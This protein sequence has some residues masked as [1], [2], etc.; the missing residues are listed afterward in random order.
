MQN[1][2]FSFFLK[3]NIA[4]SVK[5]PESK[6]THTGQIME[7]S[8]DSEFRAAVLNAAERLQAKLVRFSSRFFGGDIGRGHDV[9]QH[10]FLQLC[11]M[12]VEACP[13]NMDA[14]LFRVC[15]NRAIDLRRREDRQVTGQSGDWMDHM[16]DQ[17]TPVGDKL[18]E[19]ELFQ[20]V[21]Q[22]IANLPESQREA[23]ELWSNGFCY[24]EI[25]KILERPESTV[26]VLVH[27]AL[28]KLRT[29][30][31]IIAATGESVSTAG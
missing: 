31:R 21:Q 15:R 11:R 29:D 13:Q 5:I 18:S 1:H 20:L 2:V 3:Q 14:W 22:R 4:Y 9:V 23:I 12:G 8:C 30:K 7:A 27:R 10:A 17:R 24:A 28:T 6:T 16:V 19:H 26:R 25:S